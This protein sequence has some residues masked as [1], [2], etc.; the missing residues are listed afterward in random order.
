M[1]LKTLKILLLDAAPEHLDQIHKSHK[2]DHDGDDEI[3]LAPKVCKSSR[4]S[5]QLF[6]KA[7][8][9]HHLGL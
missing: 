3:V 4:F 2:T 9:A 7:L 1:S 6:S 8:I 5:S